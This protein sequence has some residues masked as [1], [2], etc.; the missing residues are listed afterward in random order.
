MKNLPI[1]ATTVVAVARNIKVQPGT[2]QFKIWVDAKDLVDPIAKKHLKG[3]AL[4]DLTQ[5]ENDDYWSEVNDAV[6]DKIRSLNATKVSRLDSKIPLEVD[7]WSFD[8]SDIEIDPAKAGFLLE[9]EI[10]Y[11]LI[12]DK[13]VA[14]LLDAV[15]LKGVL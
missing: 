8:A 13:A 14:P 12:G 6:T 11:S 4:K 2:I 9:G 1:G 3:R 15:G 5:D 10:E 7:S